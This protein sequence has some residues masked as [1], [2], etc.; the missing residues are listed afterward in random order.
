MDNSKHVIRR[1]STDTS[2]TSE[3]CYCLEMF[4]LEMIDDDD[5]VLMVSCS[6]WDQ[7]IWCMSTG[8]DEECYANEERS[9]IE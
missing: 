1:E 3:K 6:W 9:E 5:K 8:I 4:T 2:E 7:T